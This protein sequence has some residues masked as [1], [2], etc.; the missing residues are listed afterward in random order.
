MGNAATDDAS[1]SDLIPF[2]AILIAL[3]DTSEA[4]EPVFVAASE[5]LQEIMS[6]SSLSDGAGT[7]SLTEPLLLW[8]DAIGSKVVASTL[9]KGD[10]D[11]FSH[12]VCKLFAA[13]GDHSALYLAANISSQTPV[14]GDKTKGYLVQSFLRLIM[15]YTGLQGYY[16]V[17][18]EESELTLAFWY[19]F[20]EALWSAD[21]FEQEDDTDGSVP[22]P[23]KDPIQ[24]MPR[25][26]SH[27]RAF[28][29][30]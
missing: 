13:L 14:F 22:P 29:R 3:L 17:D 5:A 21:Y 9:Q 25:H 6:K 12:S 28:S 19:L 15:S 7:K 10:V 1:F 27:L 26:Q 24:F 2:I 23:S 20:Q 11:E 4:N 16:G 18:E 8:A 30:A